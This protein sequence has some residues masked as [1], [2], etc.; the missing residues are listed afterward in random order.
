MKLTLQVKEKCSFFWLRGIR[1]VRNDLCCA[2]CFIGEAYNEVYEATK[3][4]GD[5]FIEKDI[6]Q[7]STIKAYYL[8]GLSIGFKYDKNTHIAFVPCIGQNIEV[9]NDRVHIIITDARRIEFENYKP[10]PVGDFT[11]EQRLCRN[12]IFANYLLDGQPL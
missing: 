1:R 7:D 12:W 9:A 4:K 6:E 3:Y 11:Q 2:K 10:V 8:C 5:V